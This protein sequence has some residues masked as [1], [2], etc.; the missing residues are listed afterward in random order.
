MSGKKYTTE[1]V[2]RR[3]EEIYRQKLWAD[4]EESHQGQFL[5][6]DIETEEYEI[7]ADDLTATK[8][9]LARRPH[10]VLYGLRIGSPAAY[11]LG[12]QSLSS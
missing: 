2:E 4:V 12:G 5:V 10:A 11:R 6:L 8:R 9:L 7:A 1:E 3:G